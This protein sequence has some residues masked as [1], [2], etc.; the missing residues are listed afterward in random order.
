MISQFATHAFP[1]GIV[2]DVAIASGASL[3]C[4]HDSTDITIR[5]NSQRAS[6]LRYWLD[7]SKYDPGRSGLQ[8]DEAQ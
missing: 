7:F 3:S 5:T 4:L 2:T 1:D 8:F 6:L